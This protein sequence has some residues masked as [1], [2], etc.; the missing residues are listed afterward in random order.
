MRV[1][2][3]A[4]FLLLS[5]ITRVAFAATVEVSGRIVD[6]SG[7]A[8]PGV[9]VTL[10]AENRAEPLLETVTNGEGGY[11]L[12]AD[13]GR[14]RIHAEL[15]GFASID[16][17]LLVDTAP[18][19]LDLQLALAAVVQEVTVTAVAP[20][21]L[22]D[23]TQPDAPLTVSREVIDNA[24]LPNS[25][26]DDVLPLMPNV[27]RGPDGAISVGGGGGPRGGGGGSGLKKK[28]NL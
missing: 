15:P 13:P 1:R 21:P 16:R 25:Q 23:D 28:Q 17:E 7:G 19:R 14:Y 11:T 20:R 2:A 6:P 12:A 8:L 18:V 22:L 4:A 24:M 3:F 5:C 10:A 27:V 26:Y 9:T